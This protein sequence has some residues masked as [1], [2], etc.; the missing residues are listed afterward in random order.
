M[1]DSFEEIWRELAKEPSDINEHLE[2]LY[3]LVVDNNLKGVVELGAGRSTY[4]LLAA[5]QKTG[6][7][8]TTIDIAGHQAYGDRGN[9]FLDKLVNTDERWRLIQ[10]DSLLP[11]L[12][13]VDL[14]FV[15]TDHTFN[16][17]VN[18]VI[19][20]SRFLRPTSYIVFHDVCSP[21]KNHQVKEAWEHYRGL[22]KSEIDE[23]LVKFEETLYENN[24]GL[25]VVKVS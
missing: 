7:S 8:L 13:N 11:M 15:D 16:R 14:L 24:N 18:E 5:V 6:G 23:G 9:R 20:W 22:L 2:T 4:A 12:T 25:L 21:N 17:T 10:S 3:N 1:T 19:H